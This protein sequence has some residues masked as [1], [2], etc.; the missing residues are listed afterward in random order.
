MEEQPLNSQNFE[1]QRE[2]EAPK[3]LELLDLNDD[4]LYSMFNRF[5]VSDLC[6]LSS[7]CA[8]M[9]ALTGDYFQRKYTNNRLDL[10][11][12]NWSNKQADGR[13]R[14][15]T[16]FTPNEEYTKTFHKFIRNVGIF[17]YN[18][19]T[20]PMDEFIYLKENCNEHL[21][22][23]VLYRISCQTSEYAELI[24]SQLKTLESVKFVNCQI[25]DIHSN[26]LKYC[27][28]LKQLAI[29]EDR[30]QNDSAIEWSTQ[31]YPKLKSFI[32][33]LNEVNEEV[34]E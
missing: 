24:K 6:S 13:P 18:Q 2:L 28:D 3:S 9:Q 15:Q 5:Q 12:F 27:P 26:F 25:P 33:Y 31:H 8:R 20:D 30:N 29:K 22:E 7:T 21:R 19:K 16:Q 11:I 23:L 17:I 14:R 32:Y 10:E 34:L 1:V 4:V